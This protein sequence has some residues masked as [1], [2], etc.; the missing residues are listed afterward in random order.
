LKLT[1]DN[2][3]A[4]NHFLIPIIQQLRHLEN[5]NSLELVFKIIENTQISL[6]EIARHLGKVPPIQQL[7]LKAKVPEITSKERRRSRKILRNVQTLKLDVSVPQ[8]PQ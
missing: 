6:R 2:E 5:L 3:L 8:K 4:L 7:T 1:F